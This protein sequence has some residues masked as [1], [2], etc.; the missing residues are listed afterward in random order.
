MY[1]C[2]YACMYVC[3]YANMYACMYACMYVC[4]YANMYVC[5]YVCM[6]AWKW[7]FIFGGALVN[8]SIFAVIVFFNFWC[9]KH[10]QFLIFQ[11]KRMNYSTLGDEKHYFF[12]SFWE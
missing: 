8:S 10:V 11:M 7:L 6:C 12:L 9:E 3:M 4:M 5:M 1:V 2:M